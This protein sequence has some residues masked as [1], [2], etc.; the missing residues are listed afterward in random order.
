MNLDTTEM[1][2]KL[3]ELRGDKTQDEVAKDLGI[4]KSALSMYEL[5]KRI[6]RD[7]VKLRFSEYYK[8]SVQFIFFN[9]KEH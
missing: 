5:G 6:P 9:L 8:K 7:S 1:A 4:S 2:K 3:V